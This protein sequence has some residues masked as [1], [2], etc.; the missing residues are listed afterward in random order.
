MDSVINEAFN[1]LNKYLPHR[2]SSEV[3]KN[4]KV[5]GINV[6]ISTITNVRNR[7]NGT[8][9]LDVLNELLLI[10]KRNETY[11][12]EMKKIIKP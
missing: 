9:R 8:K 4:L 7:T 12:K 2:Y 10:A 5:K 3:K 6:S 1:F 11:I